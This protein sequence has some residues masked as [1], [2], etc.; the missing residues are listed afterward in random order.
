[1]YLGGNR[2]IGVRIVWC[3]FVLR[4]LVITP[5]YNLRKLPFSDLQTADPYKIYSKLGFLVGLP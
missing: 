4:H 1:M 2:Y 5:V 3:S